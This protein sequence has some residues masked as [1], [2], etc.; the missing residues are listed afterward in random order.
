MKR[1]LPLAAA[2]LLL[3]LSGIVHGLWTGRWGMAPDL[4]KAAARCDQVAMN[5]G[6]WEGQA[7]EIDARQLAQ[8]EVVGHCSRL[9]KNRL[10]GQEVMILLICGR[11]GPISVHTPDVCYKGAGYGIVGEQE[12]YRSEAGAEFHTARFAKPGVGPDPLRIFWA[13]S[14]AGAPLRAPENPRLAFARSEALYKLYVI[15]R[16]RNV[17]EPLDSDPCL[18]FF[19]VFVPELKKCLSPNP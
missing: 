1:M 4:E 16:M 9:Y 6:E 17:E 2:F 8:A 11:R 12:Q 19:K 3:A 15:R 13:W 5:L 14:D 18:D 7:T 10:T